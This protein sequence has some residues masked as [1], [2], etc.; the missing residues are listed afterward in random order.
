MIIEGSSLL[1]GENFL[2]LLGSNVCEEGMKET[3]SWYY[4]K[5]EQEKG[6]RF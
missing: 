6:T 3:C 5:M 1:A 4:M 2:C